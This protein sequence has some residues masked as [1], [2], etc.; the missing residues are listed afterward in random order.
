[1]NKNSRNITILAATL[2]LPAIAARAARTA[3]GYSIQGATGINEDMHPEHPDTDL[4][5]AIVWTL[6]TGACANL[7]RLS[8][9][10]W[11]AT[12]PVLNRRNTKRKAESV[13]GE[14]KDAV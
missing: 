2:F 14:I 5:H 1:M 13:A 3:A 8:V 7:A 9:Q 4:K 6:I 11:M 12:S 10:R